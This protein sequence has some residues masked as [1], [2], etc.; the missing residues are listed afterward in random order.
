MSFYAP[1]HRIGGNGGNPFHNYDLKGKVLERI[2]V[3]VGPSQIR[4]IRVWMSG[5]APVTYGIPEGPLKE[6]AFNPGERIARLSLWGNG[7]GTRTGAIR[8]ETSTGRVFDHGMTEWGRKT[9]YHIDVA[10]GICVGVMGNAGSEIDNMGF[11]FLKDV[12]R[13]TLTNVKYPT[14]DTQTP[15]LVPQDLDSFYDHNTGTSARNYKFAGSRVEETSETW[16][17]TVGLELYMEI[18]VQAGIPEV[19]SASAK[20]GWKVSASSTYSLT[21][22][23]TR[24]LSWESSGTLQ[25]GE[26]IALAA[27]T[28]RGKLYIPYTGTMVVTMRTGETFSYEVEGAYQG[29]SYA[30]VT[31]QNL[32]QPAALRA[33]LRLARQPLA[34][35]HERRIEELVPA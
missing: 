3:W 25:P 18:T 21:Q 32:P 23:S 9:E 6:F 20:F 4:A 33:P 35:V 34:E 27:V 17:A 14:L 28:A 7:I 12:A 5:T 26:S 10:S 29:V 11:V 19:M 31:I 22:K 13:A 2:A 15:S 8:F 24:T 1:V 30:G 16:S